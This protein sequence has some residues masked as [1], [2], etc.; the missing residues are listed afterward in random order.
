MDM[1]SF[2]PIGASIGGALIGLSGL[3]LFGMIGRQAG[4]SSI[5]GGLMRLE[6]RD[7]DWRLAFIIGLI[8]APLGWAMFQGIELP[9]EITANPWLLGCAGLLVGFGTRLGGGCTSG[10]GICGIS[11]LS[12][13]SIAAVAIFLTAAVATATLMRLGGIS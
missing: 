9:F 11:Q 3:F 5:A 4:V 1:D 13:R 7:L 10:H 2:T 8:I 12:V 6:L